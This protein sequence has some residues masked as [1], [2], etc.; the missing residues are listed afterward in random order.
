VRF[1]ASAVADGVGGTLRGEDVEVDGVT[2]DSRTGSAGCLFVP[3]VAG[4]DGH[5]FVGNAVAAGASAYLSSKG[6]VLDERVPVIEVNDTARALLD[7][8]LLARRH[9]GDRVVGITGSVGKTSTKDLLAAVLA[10]TWETAASERSF[11]NELGVPLTLANA[12][13]DT[14]AV[15]VEMGAR[16]HHHISVLCAIARPTIG[17]VTAVAP[18]HLQM[19]G[20]VEEVAKAKGELVE[21]LPAHGA[22]VLNGDDPLVSAMSARASARVVTFG[23]GR[24]TDVR[25]EA[26]RVADDLRTCFRL[27]S[28][29]GSVMVE[30]AVHG[31]HHVSNGLAAAAAGLVCGVELEA[32]AA[33]LSHAHLSSMRMELVRTPSGAVLL[34]DA[35]N[36][37]PTSTHAALEALAR[38]PAERRT[39]VLGPMAELGP[40]ADQLHA[41]VADYARRLGVRTITVAAQEYGVG[42]A[43][44]VGSA[45]E[46]RDRLGPLGPGDAVLVKGSRVAELERLCQSLLEP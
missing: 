26:V 10:T 16:A 24:H 7:I 30:L 19:F 17:V 29:W 9:L 11:N 33:G 2:I 38:L 39:A 44:A 15:V 42:T 13:E 3:I 43:D 4:R 28:E 40:D 41:D 31:E 46:A 12:A 14:E 35:Y 45:A 32:V 21:A 27:V 37:N 25:A 34:N 6:V 23:R 20:T 1:R 36:A 18:A 8:G 22:A 5:D